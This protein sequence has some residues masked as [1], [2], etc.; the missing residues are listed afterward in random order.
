MIK[1][2]VIRLKVVEEAKVLYG[3]E[4]VKKV[5]ELIQH[6][7]PSKVMEDLE[8]ETLKACLLHLFEDDLNK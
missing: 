2:T 5:F 4:S 1:A 8:D 3:E 6:K 7:I